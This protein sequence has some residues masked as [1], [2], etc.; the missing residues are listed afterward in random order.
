[1]FASPRLGYSR[2][3]R[4]RACEVGGSVR[5]GAEPRAI[6]GVP[7]GEPAPRACARSGPGQN[8]LHQA[9]HRQCQGRSPGK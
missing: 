2:V 5:G 1:M 6:R 8:W 7:R 3:P 4:D 9:S